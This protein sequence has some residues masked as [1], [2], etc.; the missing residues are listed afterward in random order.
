MTDAPAA[1]SFDQ[2]REITRGKFG[3]TDVPCPSCGPQ[4]RSAANQRRKTMRLWCADPN[5]ISFHCARCGEQGWA[6]NSGASRPVAPA[7]ETIAIAAEV[8]RRELDEAR[9]RL[10]LSLRLWRRRVPIGGTAA[11]TYLREARGYGGRLPDTL[12]FLPASG[13]YSSALIAAFGLAQEA[14]PGR[15]EFTIARCAAST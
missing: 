3:T 9:E 14:L 5:F 12:G 2:A 11:E 8:Q 6:S 15:S 13:D 10:K 7:P 4:R 1:L